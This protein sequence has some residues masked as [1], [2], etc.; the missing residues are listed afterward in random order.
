MLIVFPCRTFLIHWLGMKKSWNKCLFVAYIYKYKR[1]KCIHGGQLDWM[2]L[3]ILEVCDSMR[4][5]AEKNTMRP[6]ASG[7]SL[8]PQNRKKY[9]IQIYL[10]TWKHITLWYN[11]VWLLLLLFS[12]ERTVN[13]SDVWIRRFMNKTYNMKSRDS[14][15]FHSAFS[16]PPWIWVVPQ[17]MYL[18]FFTQ[19]R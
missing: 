4:L 14:W 5:F 9:R 15:Q 13:F 19:S 18:S 12:Q 10:E 16:S 2:I 8:N 6:Y 1:T 11:F 17:I 7:R 3:M